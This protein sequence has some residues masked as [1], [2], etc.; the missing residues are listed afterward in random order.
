MRR[1]ALAVTV[2]AAAMVLAFV[3]EC[4]SANAGKVMLTGKWSIN[5][6]GGGTYYLRQIN[7]EVWWIGES[8][9]GGRT[10][11]NIGHGQIKGK[12]LTVRWADAPRGSCSGSGIITLELVTKGDEVV[13]LRKTKQD[14]ANFGGDTFKPLK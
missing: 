14:G 11:T 9:D 8:P 5:C 3:G 4:S 6:G 13:E 7:D 1:G 2:V 12:V 10:W